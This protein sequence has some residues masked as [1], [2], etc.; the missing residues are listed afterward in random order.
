MPLSAGAFWFSFLALLAM[1][2]LPSIPVRWGLLG[3]ALF[4]S[5]G[6][7]ATSLNILLDRSYYEEPP[8]VLG[9]LTQKGRFFFSPPLMRDATRLQGPSMPEAYDTAKQKMYP[10]WPLTF[11]REEAPIYNTLQLRNSLDWA[12]RAFQYSL[13]HS[14][15]VLDYLGIRYVFGKTR[16]KDLKPHFI[17]KDETGSAVLEVSENP[18]PLPKWFSIQKAIP[19]SPTLEEDFAKAAQTHLDYGKECFV[20][21]DSKTGT[22]QARKAGCF[23]QGPN[24]LELEATGAGKTLLVSSETAYPGWKAAV[25]GQAREVETI[26]HS[27]RGILLKDGE[28]HARFSFE[29][30]TF[31]LGLFCA[32]VICAFWTFLIFRR[33]WVPSIGG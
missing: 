5:L 15:K 29:P 25:N 8:K 18:N 28:T 4:L 31:R 16:F 21:D 1:G 27:F 11:G 12:L 2:F 20:G 3:L 14:R 10:D 24:R 9:E 30:S 13:P 26:N 6:K 17:L 19:A 22:Y 32:L 33:Y 7:A 23:L